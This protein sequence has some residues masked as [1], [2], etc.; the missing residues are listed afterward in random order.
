MK[1]L[2]L[3]FR[4]IILGCIYFIIGGFMTAPIIIGCGT[5]DCWIFALGLITFPVGAAVLKSFM[6]S[7][8]FSRL[9]GEENK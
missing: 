7:K 6:W 9:M 3:M 1:E 4:L 2:I 8:L 5:S